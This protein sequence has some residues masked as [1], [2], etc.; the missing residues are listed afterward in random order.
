MVTM[1]FLY[2]VE[3]LEYAKYLGIDVNT[4]QDLL[5]IAVEGVKSQFIHGLV[6]SASARD[7]EG[8]LV[9]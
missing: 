6:E 4:E 2:D 9:S 3:I 1:R 7:M 5:W 8:H